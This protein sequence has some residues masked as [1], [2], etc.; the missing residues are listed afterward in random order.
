MAEQ[1]VDYWFDLTNADDGSGAIMRQ[2][3]TYAY[4][5]EI[6]R[7]EAPAEGAGSKSFTELMAEALP[8]IQADIDA[9]G[10]AA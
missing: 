1:A 5:N 6:D 9:Y 10:I 3:V 2:C 7:R 4:G 8:A